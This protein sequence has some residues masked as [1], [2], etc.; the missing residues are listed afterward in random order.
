MMKQ[1]NKKLFAISII[2]IIIYAW[3]LGVFGLYGAAITPFIRLISIYI[4]K[5]GLIT[6]GFVVFAIL[7]FRIEAAKLR[8]IEN[9]KTY[10]AQLELAKKRAEEAKLQRIAKKLEETQ[11]YE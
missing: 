3:I 4:L 7:P 5:Y 6:L 10:Q 9:A 1:S 11:N 8:N 2:S